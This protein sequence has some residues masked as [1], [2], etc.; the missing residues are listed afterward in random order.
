[1]NQKRHKLPFYL[2][3]VGNRNVVGLS[4]EEKDLSFE[5]ETFDIILGGEILSL[6]DARPNVR[7]VSQ[8]FGFRGYERASIL[9]AFL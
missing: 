2:K 7:M 9:I 4:E 8:M 1:M 3:T 6:L 5:P